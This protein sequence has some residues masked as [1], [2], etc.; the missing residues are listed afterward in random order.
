MEEL[1]ETTAA[2]R[3]LL[4]RYIRTTFKPGLHYGIIPV[5]GQE[6][7]KP[8]LLKPGA[9]MFCLLFGWRAGFSADLPILQMYGPGITGTVLAGL[10]SAHEVH[11]H[12]GGARELVLQILDFLEKP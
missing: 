9:E 7:S 2:V 3:A 11:Y 5:S 10:I 12:R 4:D 6:T 8:T 1:V